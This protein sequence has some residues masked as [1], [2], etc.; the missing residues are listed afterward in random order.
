MTLIV[1][2]KPPTGGQTSGRTLFGQQR[3]KNGYGQQNFT[4]PYVKEGKGPTILSK[5]KNNTL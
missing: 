3:K 4:M 2:K 5:K 1:Q